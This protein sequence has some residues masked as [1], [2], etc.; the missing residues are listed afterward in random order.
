MRE[1][2]RDGALLENGFERFLRRSDDHP[3]GCSRSGIYDRDFWLRHVPLLALRRFARRMHFARRA[4]EPTSSHRAVH[5]RRSVGPYA[6]IAAAAAGPRLDGPFARGARAVPL[7]PLR[8]LGSDHS[9]R[10]QA[11]PGRR[12][13]C[14]AAGGRSRGS[15][16]ARRS[17]P[18]SA[19]RCRSP[20]GSSGGFND[21][22]RD[23][24]TSSGAA[25]AGFL[26]PGEVER[27]FDEHR[28]GRRQPRPASLRDRDVRLLVE[29][30]ASV[31]P[32]DVRER[33]VT[34][35]P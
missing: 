29:R 9:G 28:R 1:R 27:T 20:T 32:R 17:G 23:A 3:A 10:P 13:I 11:A 25:D 34:N 18:S 19:S 7:A 6:G 21:F 5:A 30:P 16:R 2:F 8:R 12:E 31:Q 26:D 33:R 15:R 14:A 4:S 24:W 35:K 22:A